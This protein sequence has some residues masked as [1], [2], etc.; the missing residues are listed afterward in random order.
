MTDYLFFI[1]NSITWTIKSTYSEKIAKFLDESHPLS[2]ESTN[3]VK[4]NKVRNVKAIKLDNQTHF[5]FKHYK[6]TKISDIF[7]NMFFKSKAKKEWTNA[8]EI[9]KRGISVG[10]PLAFGE[11]RVNRIITD[12][13]LIVKAVDDSISLRDLLLNKLTHQTDF[14]K[15]RI[16]LGALAL[17]VHDLHLKGI[18]HNDLHTG[19]ILIPLHTI[20]TLKTSS[21]NYLDNTKNRLCLIDLHDVKCKKDI[22][23]EVQ[24]EN[25]AFLLYSLTFCTTRTEIR[26]V[27]KLYLGNSYNNKELKTITKDINNNILQIQRK[28]MFSRTKRCLKNSSKFSKQCWKYKNN[29]IITEGNYKVYLNNDYNKKEL[30]AA[31]SAHNS[32]LKDN[33]NC[34]IKNSSRI[35]ITTIDSPTDKNRENGNVNKENKLCIKEFKNNNILKQFRETFCLSR[36]RKAWYAA[37]G[38]I[39]RNHT[40]PTPVAML[41]QNQFGLVKSSFLITQYIDNAIPSYIYVNQTFNLPL[42]S[43][44]HLF[45]NKKTFTENLAISFRKLHQSNIYHADLKGGNVLVKETGE[46]SRNFFYV[47]LDRVFFKKK[48]PHYNIHKNLTQLNASLPNSFSFTDRIRFFK[49]Y[50]NIKKLSKKDKSLINKIVK[51]SIKRKHFW[52]PVKGKSTTP[53]L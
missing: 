46:N 32:A 33:P 11:K 8:N 21:A 6:T 18:L 47:D 14:K 38:F 24:L 2:N 31:L 9:L 19:N 37:N 22:S 44:K 50:Y 3:V 5:Y 49:T 28:H 20:D 40:T 29:A 36:A 10:E 53:H 16:I 48:L 25:L 42:T 43:Q 13:F 41:E 35:F 45:A 30:E 52:N 51:A 27:I 12:N 4:S 26:F 34:I 15:R 1:K 39:V 17:F 23:P 7:K